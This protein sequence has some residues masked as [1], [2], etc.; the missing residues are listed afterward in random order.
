MLEQNCFYTRGILKNFRPLPKFQAW[1]SMYPLDPLSTPLVVIPR[2][3]VASGGGRGALP[4][5]FLFLPPPPDFIFALPDLFLALPLYFFLKMSIAL[6]VKIVVIL[7]V[8]SPIRT[9]ILFD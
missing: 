7:T 1:Y 6:T 5:R 8:P 9:S 4:P 3:R 2:R